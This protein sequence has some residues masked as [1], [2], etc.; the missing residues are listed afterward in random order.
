MSGGRRNTK[1]MRG[2]M[3]YGFNGTIGTAGAVHGASWGGEVTK[4][5][6]PVFDTADPQRGSA[7]RGGERVEV[8]MTSQAE[9]DRTGIPG[10]RAAGAVSVMERKEAEE[11]GYYVIGPAP[12]E[13]GRR[14]TKKTKKTKKAKKTKKVKKTKS[15]RRT[16]R[17]G[18]SAYNTAPTGHGYEGQ[19]VRGLATY[20]AYPS[21]LPPAGAHS[22]N[23]DGVTSV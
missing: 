13:G 20:S 14:K 3:G 21:N 19:G 8:A 12:P 2:G 17:G 7:R 4:S 23:A 22:V 11:K 5:G 16:M 15:R 18:A 1:K 6:T 9:V 10:L